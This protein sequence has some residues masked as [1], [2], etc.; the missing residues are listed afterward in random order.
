MTTV[1]L[2]FEHDAIA[3]F[4]ERLTP[5]M[6][7]AVRQNMLWNLRNAIDFERRRKQEHEELEQYITEIADKGEHWATW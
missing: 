3:D 7:T 1:T 5:D 6:Q 4:V 2:A